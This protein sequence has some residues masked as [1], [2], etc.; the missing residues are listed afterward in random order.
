MANGLT[1]E[2]RLA[3]RE[4]LEKR[5]ARHGQASSQQPSRLASLR[6]SILP[7]HLE[8]TSDI[9]D[10]FEDVPTAP[11]QVEQLAD[12]PEPEAVPA[13]SNPD[14][15]WAEIPRNYNKR[16][17]GVKPRTG[18]SRPVKIHGQN[19]IMKPSQ[20]HTTV[21]IPL[22]TQNRVGSNQ[23]SFSGKGHNWRPLILGGIVVV[24]LLFIIFFVASCGK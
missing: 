20:G 24:I 9:Q 2:Q 11:E 4:R 15:S 5:Q 23:L 14:D 17:E 8:V 21:T 7:E 13:Q 18:G 3:A 6:S 19:D 16:P 10:E 1:D 12:M 22:I